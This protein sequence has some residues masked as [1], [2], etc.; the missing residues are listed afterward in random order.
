MGGTDPSL[1]GAR[2][3]ANPESRTRV[4]SVSIPGLR[5]EAHPGMTIADVGAYFGCSFNAA[6]LMQ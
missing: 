2:L 4:P 1:R 3:R 6:E 5:Q